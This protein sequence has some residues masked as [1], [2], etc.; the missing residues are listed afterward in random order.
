LG[1]AYAQAGKEFEDRALAAFR[2]GRAHVPQGELDNYLRQLP[3]TYR[4]QM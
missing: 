4:S 2:E 3:L 1:Q